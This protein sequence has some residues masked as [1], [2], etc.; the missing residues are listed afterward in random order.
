MFRGK[1]VSEDTPMVDGKAKYSSFDCTCRETM[2]DDAARRTEQIPSS[3]RAKA[4][5]FSITVISYCS[6]SL[7]IV[8]RETLLFMSTYPIV[9][10][11]I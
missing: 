10:S 1:T 6:D 5:V 9:V 3:L 4:V 7:F 11:L 2:R 8:N